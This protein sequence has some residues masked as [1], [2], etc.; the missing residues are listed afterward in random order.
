MLQDVPTDRETT[1]PNT[2]LYAAQANWRR[3]YPRS[4]QTW[5][6]TSDREFS[7]A[8]SDL[9]SSHRTAES[10]VPQLVMLAQPV[11]AEC[12]LQVPVSTSKHW[13]CPIYCFFFL[14]LC[15]RCHFF[16]SLLDA[17]TKVLKQTTMDIFFLTNCHMQHVCLLFH[18]FCW[19]V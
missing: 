15:S 3:G 4:T 2:T 6:P 5:K 16:L 12:R 14:Q 17:I 13:S 19:N 1:S 9:V 18:W 8:H 7:A 11:P 10:G